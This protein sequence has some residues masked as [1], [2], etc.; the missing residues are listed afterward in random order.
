MA[1]MAMYNLYTMKPTAQYS[2]NDLLRTQ[3]YLSVQQQRLARLAERTAE[4]KS[5]LI[6]MAID[7]FLDAQAQANSAG[8][9]KKQ[10]L[11]Q[12]AGAWSDKAPVDLRALRSGW[13]RRSA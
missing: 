1:D 7:R 5:G 11:A 2:T 6:R 3:V 13:S 8:D 4:T 9:L 12:L 10:R